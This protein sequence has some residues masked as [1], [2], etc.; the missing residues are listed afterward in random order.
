MFSSILNSRTLKTVFYA[1]LTGAA[2]A[3]YAADTAASALPYES[4][5][6]TIQKSM[7]GPVAYSVSLIGIVACGATLIF[8]GGEISRFMRSIIYL[9]MVMGLL[10]GANTMMTSLFNGAVIEISA[11][12]K[13]AL[14]HV[15]EIKSAHE[16]PFFSKGILIEPQTQYC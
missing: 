1:V 7:T 12:E 5:L 15:N 10:I 11:D 3:A 4:W 2:N 9:V 6:K 13:K 14:N 8:A 16:D